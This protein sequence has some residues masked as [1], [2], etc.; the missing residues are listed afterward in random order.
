MPSPPSLPAA[1]AAVL[2]A[3][4]WTAL[5]PAAGFETC[6]E[7]PDWVYPDLPAVL[8]DLVHPD[9][10]TRERALSD[11]VGGAFHDLAPTRATAAVTMFFA[12]LLPDPRT[13]QMVRPFD[14]TRSLRCELLIWTG[15]F[16]ADAIWSPPGGPP[17]VRAVG[18]RFHGVRP[19]LFAA[20]A[21]HLDDPDP[22]TRDNALSCALLLA[23]DR[24]LAAHRDPL[25]PR[26]RRFLADGRDTDPNADMDYELRSRALETLRTWGH[27]TTGLGRADEI[28]GTPW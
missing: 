23:G 3:T 27:D 21:E 22:R 5:R 9:V 1:A 7:C 18:D 10:A 14:P 8:P 6:P 26:A 24:D 16:L 17:G 12:A 20:V 25:V 2:V 28:P 4:D 11:A 13:A 15:E 19:Q